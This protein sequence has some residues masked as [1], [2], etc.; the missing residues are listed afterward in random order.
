MLEYI[1]CGCAHTNDPN[2]LPIW[3]YS[4]LACSSLR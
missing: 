4:S 1:R 2:I 3:D